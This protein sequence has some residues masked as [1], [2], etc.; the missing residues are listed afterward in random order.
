MLQLASALQ[1]FSN[2]RRKT[3]TQ[4]IFLTNHNKHNSGMNQ[5]ELGASTRNRRQARETR[6][7]EARLVLTLLLI[8]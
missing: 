6:A 5:S 1:L 7:S 4:V 8:G 2:Q 3:K